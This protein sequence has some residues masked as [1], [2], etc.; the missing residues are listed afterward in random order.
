MPLIVGHN[1]PGYLPDVDPVE[2]DTLSEA[3]R[4]LVNDVQSYFMIET[5]GDDPEMTVEE[6]RALQQKV[7][8]AKR[9]STVIL[10]GHAFWI[11]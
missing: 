8:C 3:I 11:M 7:L 2:V 6:I 10:R 1:D 4:C 5:E 9:N